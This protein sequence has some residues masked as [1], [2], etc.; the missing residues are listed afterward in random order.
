MNF[1]L[2]YSFLHVPSFDEYLQVKPQ[3]IFSADNNF[4]HDV[5]ESSL[6][7]PA[8]YEE[9]LEFY[10][11]NDWDVWGISRMK[12]GDKWYKCY[13]HFQCNTQPKIQKK[14]ERFNQMV[15][16]A[17]KDIV[18][19]DPRLALVLHQYNFENC[20]FI[21]IKR[22]PESVRKSMH[23]H[24]GHRMFTQSTLPD[25]RYVS[26]HFNY[27]IQFQSFDNYVSNYTRV[28]EEILLGK[29]HIVLEMEEL[30][31]GASIGALETFIDRP[32]DQSVID[33]SAISF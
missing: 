8:D 19:K 30:L 17:K 18:L 12:K 16:S 2:Q 21:W 7:L 28:I 14:V 5:D 3:N 25:T 1:G 4:S 31:S 6:Y 22:A 23:K 33:Q 32:I 11:G 27:K 9:N 10:H 24:Y 20:D 15:H 13:E 26:N 29:R